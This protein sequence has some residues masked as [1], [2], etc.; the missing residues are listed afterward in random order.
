MLRNPTF[1]AVLRESFIRSASQAS[2]SRIAFPQTRLLHTY[3]PLQQRTSPISSL[4]KSHKTPPSK[5]R[6]SILRRTRNTRQN[7]NQPA[8]P[9]PQEVGDT[10]HLSLSERFR[11]LSRKYGWAAVGVYFGLS[12]LDF[13]FCFL[14][15]RFIGTERIGEAEHAIVHG[16][17]SLVGLVLPGMKPQDKVV[18][19]GDDHVVKI[20]SQE[21]KEDA[22]M[23]TNEH[24]FSE[25]TANELSKGIWTQLLLAY[26]V[27]KSLIFF[28]IPLTAA[29]T[30]KIVKTLRG[31]GWN[32]GRPERA[33]RRARRT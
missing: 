21:E 10:S 22:S 9:T 25:Q 13:P 32:I 8:G 6:S 15:V 7:S 14:A 24:P 19:E 31:W 2:R 23:Y 1:L 26:G 4:S 3:R 33:V 27:H 12:V 16:F 30:P 18:I 20:E 17:W 28:R 11:L 5:W 29:V